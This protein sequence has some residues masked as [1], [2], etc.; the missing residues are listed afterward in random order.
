[1][2]ITPLNFICWIALLVTGCNRSENKNQKVENIK[3]YD[4]I[5]LTPQT[6]S[7]FVDYPATI[8]GQQVVEIRPMVDGYLQNIYVKEG[9][10]V[11]KGQLLF[12]IRNPQYD[13]EVITSQAAIQSALANVNAA[14]MEVEKVRP[15]VSKDIVSKYQLDAAQ[16][17]LQAQEAALEEARAAYANAKTNQGYTTIVSPQEGVIGTIPY[18]VGALVSSTSAN[19]L[20]ILSNIKYVYA[21][22]GLNE[23]QLLS[24]STTIKGNTMQEKLNQLPAVTLLLADGSEY[25]EQGKLETASGLIDT[26]TGSAQFKAIFPNPTGLIP[27]GASAVVRIPRT[28][29]T[30]LLVPQSASYEVQDKRFVFKVN[31]DN[32]AI[33]TAITAIPTND[34][35]FWIVQNGLTVGDRV[36]INSATLKDSTLIKVRLLNADSLYN[37]IK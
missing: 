21:Y 7:I 10:S 23:K 12:K 31:N 8:E 16:Y 15:L 14:K 9:A 29:D 22:F 24:F 27:S 28:I 20:T 5:V 34:G 2:R 19:A 25:P 1:M 3:D 13:Q 37:A 18:K 6:A 35:Q 36:V 4:V 32:Q 11:K 26:E 17:N 33:S 30:A